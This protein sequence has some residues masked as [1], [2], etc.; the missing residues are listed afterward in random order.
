MT[1]RKSDA[2]A[3]IQLTSLPYDIFLD[4]FIYLD[5]EDICCLLQVSKLIYVYASDEGIWRMLASRQGINDLTNF[6]QH[7]WY[8]VYTGLLHKYGGLLGL[9]GSD[10]PFRGNILEC[11]IN[12]DGTWYGILGEVWKF[13]SA[14]EQDD[15][16]DPCLPSY[17]ETFRI[18]LA[19]H[20]DS[21]EGKTSKRR[22]FPAIW[23]PEN[24]EA[25]PYSDDTPSLLLLS[26]T[27]QAS[28]IHVPA[29]GSSHYRSQLPDFPALGSVWHD[30]LRDMSRFPRST[31]DEY[32]TVDQIFA[33]G[34]L[35]RS[36]YFYLAQVDYTFPEALTIDI[37]PQ[38]RTQM[39]LHR[40]R[41][42][43]FLDDFRFITHRWRTGGRQNITDRYYPIRKAP[44]T[45][46][47]TRTDWHPRN[48]EGLWLGAYGP[49]G[50]E[51]LY[52]EW[53]S[54]TNEVRAW[55]IT[56]DYNVPRGVISWRFTVQ[57]GMENHHELPSNL[58][59]FGDLRPFASFHGTGT[60]S[61]AGF[62]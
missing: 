4:L 50:T 20:R 42:P 35:D 28:F 62:L 32:F 18:E 61:A 6:G 3:K 5:P 27:N 36:G 54:H 13:P 46:E 2:S 29:P 60:I 56:G 41:V 22:D 19:P 15:A 1:R 37:P 34:V 47:S 7:T 16:R 24:E 57:P 10:Y 45:V 38:C 12:E 43:R 44:G 58:N 53:A 51:V 9:W 11:R 23:Y 26:S 31:P 17:A 33:P 39:D 40:P 59:S 30:R 55:K 52:I 49:H 14:T 25:Q 21:T 48:L 8:E